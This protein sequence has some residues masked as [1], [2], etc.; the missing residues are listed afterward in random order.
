MFC[1]NCGTQVQAQEA[2]VCVNCGVQLI[3]KTEQKPFTI[4]CHRCGNQ[5]LSEEAAV[6]VNCGVR[7]IKRAEN[8]P[9]HWL[10]LILCGI[11]FVT[12]GILGG[13]YDLQEVNNWDYLS[14]PISI[15]ALFSGI[16]LIPRDRIALKVTC[17][18]LSSF[19]VL[20]TIGWS[21]A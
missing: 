4:F 21:F 3:K 11:T 2:V 7:I 15:A 1:H 9:Q 8:K 18:V 12:F 6:C 13:D 14:I 19:L 17:I 16:F 20:G 5:V 10:S